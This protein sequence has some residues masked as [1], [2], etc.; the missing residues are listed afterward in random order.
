ML[1]LALAR[2][3]SLPLVPINLSLEEKVPLGF[4]PAR[5][6]LMFS[7]RREGEE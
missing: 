5:V 3:G 7:K 2:Y 4:Q 6:M 1:S